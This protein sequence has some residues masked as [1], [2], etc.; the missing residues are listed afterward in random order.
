MRNHLESSPQPAS[1][2]ATA[3][4]DCVLTAAEQE[5]PCDLYDRAL[6]L[7]GEET[8]IIDAALDVFDQS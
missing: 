4:T 5:V 6:D 1:R 7:L 2:S 3:H 8:D